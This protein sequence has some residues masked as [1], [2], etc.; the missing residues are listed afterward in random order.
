MIIL[1]LWSYH[2]LGE[3]YAHV[4]LSSSTI[5][6]SFCPNIITFRICAKLQKG[7]DKN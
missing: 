1:A 3:E 6:Y 7:M 4:L 2:L 5:L